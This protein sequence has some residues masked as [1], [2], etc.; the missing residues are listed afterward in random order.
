MLNPYLN[1]TTVNTIMTIENAK[2]PHR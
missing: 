2:N 1:T